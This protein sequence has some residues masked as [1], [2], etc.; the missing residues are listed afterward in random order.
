MVFLNNKR[1]VRSD[2]KIDCK[3]TIPIELKECIYRISYVTNTPVKDIAERISVAGLKSK[4]VIEILAEHFRRDLQIGNTFYMGDL[5]RESLQK[6]KTKSKTER[7]TIRF[8]QFNFEQIRA[9]AYSLDVTPT[10]AVALLLEHTIHHTNIVN[11]LAKQYLKDNINESK[12]RELKKIIHYLN[13][14]SNYDEKISWVALLSF[15][16]DELKDSST[17]MSKAIVNWINNI[18]KN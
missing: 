17:N 7:I 2:K 3:P 13:Q 8:K 9:L 14:N 10:R 16:Y 12:M 15:F 5:E 4:K 11:R 18:K 1:K 6:I